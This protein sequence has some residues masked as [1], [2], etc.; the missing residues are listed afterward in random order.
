MWPRRKNEAEV[1]I[2]N[3]KLLFKQTVTKDRV[4]DPAEQLRLL[5]TARAN[6]RLEILVHEG[7][8]G[9]VYKGVFKKGDTYEEVIVKTV[10]GTIR[11]SRYLMYAKVW[12]PSYEAL[13]VSLSKL[14]ED[15]SNFVCI[16]LE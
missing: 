7:T 16:T 1:S 2:S 11:F 3:K 10:S 9:R 4:T 6:I 14:Q 13:D 5:T 15:R 8:F 12:E